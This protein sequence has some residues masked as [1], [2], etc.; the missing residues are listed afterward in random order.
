MMRLA[1]S[2]YSFP[3]LQRHERLQLVRLLGF[4]GVVME[5]FL[6]D[7]VQMAAFERCWREQVTAARHD[8][9]SAGLRV[10]DLFLILRGGD[11]SGGAVNAPDGAWRRRARTVFETAVRFAVELGAPAVTIL[12]GTPW[13]GASQA[14]WRCCVDE[15]GWRVDRAEHAGIGLRIEPNMGSI[16]S[17][18]ELVEHLLAE[19][20]GLA[21]VLDVSHFAAQSIGLDR[22]LPLVR[23]GRVDLVHARAAR[24]G[25]IQVE[26]PRNETDFAALFQALADAGYTGAVCVEYT[27]MR[28]WR[29]N[30]MDVLTAIV[31]T[32]AALDPLIA[33]AARHSGGL[34]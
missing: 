6:D 20:R 25:E 26:W 19:V 5:L 1:C 15:L 17:T 32:R 34:Q 30:T 9:V 3:A 24:H 2:D 29:C 10:E 23:S 18:P 8:V 22:A 33:G 14:G 16:A 27:P 7:D 21:L 12:P 11:F 4:D 13:P 28:Q 31:E